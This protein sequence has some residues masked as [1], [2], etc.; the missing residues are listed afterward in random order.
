MD[1][2]TKGAG[3]D[4][5]SSEPGCSL[6]DQWED[7]FFSEDEGAEAFTGSGFNSFQKGHQRLVIRITRNSFM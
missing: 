3:C 4:T 5:P 7:G 1:W 6:T 2:I